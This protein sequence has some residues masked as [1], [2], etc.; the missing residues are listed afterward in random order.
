MNT[1]TL[2][3]NINRPAIRVKRGRWMSINKRVLYALGN[4]ANILFWWSESSRVLLI[5]D[6]P[7]KTPLS[8]KINECYYNTKNGFQIEKSNFIQTIM[9]VTG[10]HN[11]MIYAVKGEYIAEL[12]MVAFK[13]DD[14]VGVEI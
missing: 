7:E 2:N 5:G 10:W 3:I 13:V 11:N 8:I 9:R 12:N 6:S 1:S 14:A 4:P